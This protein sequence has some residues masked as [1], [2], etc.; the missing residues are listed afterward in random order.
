LYKVA[1]FRCVF[2]LRFLPSHIEESHLMKLNSN[3]VLGTLLLGSLVLSGCASVSSLT[4][5]DAIDYKSSKSAVR[6]EVPPDLTQLRPNDRFVQRGSTSAAQVSSVNS[7]EVLPQ[8]TTARIERANGARWLVVNLPA[9]KVFPIV[10]DFWKQLGFT[11]AIESPQM[12][13]IETD[14]AENRAKL[15]QDGLR[16]LLGGVIDGLYD[17]GDRDKYRVRLERAGAGTELYISHRGTKEY[18]ASTTKEADI[19]TVQRN[20]SA[21]LEAE[22]LRR[23]LLR[24]GADEASAKAAVASNAPPKPRAVIVENTLAIDEPFESAWRR[25]GIALDRTGFTVEDRNFS[26]GVYYVRYSRNVKDED[27]GFFKRVFTSEKERLSASQKLKIILTKSG[28]PV[29][30]TVTTE[31]GGAPVGEVTNNLLKVLQD[32]LK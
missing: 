2:S 31:A 19:K 26:E 30:L 5:Q 23:L 12:G 24:F 17:T 9:E 4:D 3:A 1:F 29:K 14:W 13:V 20:G 21:E 22:F 11:L 28:V 25:T 16:K 18:N 32:E 10:T 15:P 6:L 7:N 27:L 8:S